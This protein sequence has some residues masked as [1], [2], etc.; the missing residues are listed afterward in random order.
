MQWKLIIHVIDDKSIFYS[1]F[2]K[3]W[4]LNERGYYAAEA[5]ILSVAALLLYLMYARLNTQP[6]YEPMCE[7]C[8]LAIAVCVCSIPSSE[9]LML[10]GGGSAENVSHS[11]LLRRRRSADCDD[12]GKFPMY[13]HHLFRSQFRFRWTKH[14]F[15]F[16]PRK[17]TAAWV[18]I[19]VMA[20]IELLQFS[21]SIFLSFFR[22]FHHFRK[23]FYSIFIGFLFHFDNVIFFLLILL[24]KNLL[25]TLYFISTFF[26]PFPPAASHIHLT[27]SSVLSS[28][29]R[30]LRGLH[31]YQ[32]SQFDEI[33]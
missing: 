4:L 21:S 22:F 27:W 8:S 32:C 17:L 1:V 23:K 24:P 18:M 30:A 31:P 5:M 25:F 2:S 16:H 13:A 20:T 29:L 33:W 15:D 6:D 9:M 11:L 19:M 28:L 14:M 26:W 10:S 12:D 7:V 3:L